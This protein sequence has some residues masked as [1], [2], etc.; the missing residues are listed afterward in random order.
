MQVQ[1]G[2]TTETKENEANPSSLGTPGSWETYD[3]PG[4]HMHGVGTWA[5]IPQP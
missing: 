4:Y 2:R 1:R 5:E 3:D